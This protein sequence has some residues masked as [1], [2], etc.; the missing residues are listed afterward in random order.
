MCNC[1]YCYC[2]CCYPT[3]WIV[4]CCLYRPLY[5]LMFY[6]DVSLRQ[7]EASALSQPKL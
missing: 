4:A 5:D 6:S 1:Y 2:N 3:V 7:W